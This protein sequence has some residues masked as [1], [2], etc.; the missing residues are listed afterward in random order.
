MKLHNLFSLPHLHVRQIASKEPLMNYSQSH[1]MISNMNNLLSCK[2]KLW[3]RQQHVE[4][5][6]RK[7]RKNVLGNQQMLWLW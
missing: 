3:I 2:I 5:R 6:K 1:V 4:E 7:E